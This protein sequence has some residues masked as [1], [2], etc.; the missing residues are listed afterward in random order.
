MLS[1]IMLSVITLSII[2]LSVI[3]LSVI[4]LSVIMLSVIMLSVIMLNVVALCQPLWAQ[5]NHRCLMFSVLWFNICNWCPG[6]PILGRLLAS[7]AGCRDKHSSSLCGPFLSYEEK[8]F[9]TL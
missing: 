5:F 9:L 2:M 4:M 8:R 6:A 1:V 7:P 3:M